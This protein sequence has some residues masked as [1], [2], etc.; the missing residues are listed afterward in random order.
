MSGYDCVDKQVFSR[1]WKISSDGADVTYKD[2]D[3][4]KD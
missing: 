2:Q 4:D 1:L 3:K